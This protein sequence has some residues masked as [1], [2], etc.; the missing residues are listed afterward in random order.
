MAIREIK[1]TTD[2]DLRGHFAS[3]DGV[4]VKLELGGSSCSAE[5]WCRFGDRFRAFVY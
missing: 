2:N 5:M 1:H 4:E 3:A